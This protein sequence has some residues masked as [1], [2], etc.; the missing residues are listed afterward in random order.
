MSRVPA[1][2]K[3]ELR[4]HGSLSD[5][6]PLI[7]SML[8]LSYFHASLALLA[9]ASI[10]FWSRAAPQQLPVPCACH[11]IVG[12][13]EALETDLTTDSRFQQPSIFVDAPAF[14]CC[15][16]VFLG[17]II[18]FALAT[19]WQCLLTSLRTSLNPDPEYQIRRPRALAP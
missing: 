5:L 8:A 15:G 13:S 1:V 12:S 14:G 11:C 7:V 17:F 3:H 18:A 4:T 6:S 2:H 10:G 9:S 16:G 19:G